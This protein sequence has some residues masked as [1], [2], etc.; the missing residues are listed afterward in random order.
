MTKRQ[1]KTTRHSLAW[2]LSSAEVSMKTLF[3]A[4]VLCLICILIVPSLAGVFAQTDRVIQ[5]VELVIAVDVSASMTREVGRNNFQ[6]IEKGLW[7]WNTQGLL[8]YGP[9]DGNNLSFDAVNF[10]NEWLADFITTQQVRYGEIDIRS[11]LITFDNQPVS[12]YEDEPLVLSAPTIN[13]PN[14]SG[15]RSTDFYNLYAD[16]AARFPDADNTRKRAV[17]LITDSLPCHPN[18]SPAEMRDSSGNYIREPYCQDTGRMA[19]HVRAASELLPSDVEQ[20]IYFI[21]ENNLWNNLGATELRDAWEG[22]ARRSEGAFT[23]VANIDELPGAMF[24]D[25]LDLLTR[26]IVGERIHDSATIGVF[27]YT[28]AIEVPPYQEFMD[29]IL[30]LEGEDDLPVF[31]APGNPGVLGVPLAAS[32]TGQL[33][34]LR[35]DLPE[36]GTWNLQGYNGPVWTS[37]KLAEAHVRLE[38]TDGTPVDMPHQYETV[39]VVYELRATDSTPIVVDENNLPGFD[40]SVTTESG[41]EIPLTME[42]G[43]VVFGSE[44]LLLVESGRYRFDFRVYPSW[45]ET[46][47][48]PLPE[49]TPSAEEG[50]ADATVVEDAASADAAQSGRSYNFLLPMEPLRSITVAPMTFE[51]TLGTAEQQDELGARNTITIHRSQAVP[52][53]IAAFLDGASVNIP[54]SVD[55]AVSL[56]GDGCLTVPSFVKQ[57]GRFIIADG[58]LRFEE[59]RCEVAVSLT[60]QSPLKPLNGGSRTLMSETSLGAIEAQKTARLEVLLLA[61]DGSDINQDDFDPAVMRD[62]QTASVIHY[63]MTDR[64]TIPTFDF[65]G[66]PLDWTVTWPS[67]DLVIDIVFR[68]S[69]TGELLDPGF[70]N[71][72]E[73]AATADTGADVRVDFPIPFEVSVVQLGSTEDLA[74]SNDSI[75]LVKNAREGLYSLQVSNLEPGDYEL[76]FELLRDSAEYAL[77]SAYEY[78]EDVLNTQS[79]GNPRLYAFLRVVQ[80]PLPIVQQIAAGIFV[81]AVAGY[82]VYRIGRM[83]VRTRGRLSGEIAIYKGDP[84]SDSMSDVWSSALPPNKKRINTYSF[85]SADLITPETLA[86]NPDGIRVFTGGDTVFAKRGGVKVRLQLGDNTNQYTLDPGIPQQIAKT[87]PYYIVKLAEDTA[88]IDWSQARTL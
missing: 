76:R 61:P 40:L 42:P 26:S 56:N 52:V 38:Y 14:L 41:E 75:A 19:N 3:R 22:A 12:L 55:A 44:P 13:R 32:D 18:P 43:G 11:T 1:Y 84:G 77:E 28:G 35:F 49:P 62:Q 60:L 73:N 29:V 81:I 10:I 21:G 7:L 45:D 63:Q 50:A 17:F 78:S 69:E 27:Q 80:N 82:V 8:P 53:E 30:F 39:R 57:E 46:Y 5:G 87:P 16:L 86:L 70:A 64:Q 9:T 15:Q 4:T 25:V 31:N 54:D 71:F 2:V 67:N 33:Q 24:N 79:V 6:E 48:A 65:E 83:M 34:R 59:G 74:N 85:S 68:D 47:V 88:K 58:G 20:Y 37:Y 72:N 66:D 23:Q 36:A 51:T